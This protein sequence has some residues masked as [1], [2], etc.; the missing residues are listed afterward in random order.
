MSPH[1]PIES[2][3][4]PFDMNEYRLETSPQVVDVE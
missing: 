4:R 2:S 1:A 3:W